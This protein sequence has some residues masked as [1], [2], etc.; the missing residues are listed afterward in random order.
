[1]SLQEK[2]STVKANTQAVYDKGKYDEWDNFW[3]NYQKFSGKG[4]SYIYGFAC[5]G[6]NNE[7][8]KPKKDIVCTNSIRCMFYGALNLEID[9]RPEQFFERFGVNITFSN[10]TNWEQWLAS[11]GIYAVG[12]VD[13]TSYSDRLRYTFQGAKSLKYIEKVILPSTAEPTMQTTNCFMNST[14][15]EHIRFEG[16]IG[17]TLSFQWCTLLT[18]ES[19]KDII[20]HLANYKGTQYEGQKTITFTTECWDRLEAT[21]PPEGFSTWKAYVVSKGWVT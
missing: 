3:S 10:I 9:L 6:W 18:V 7:N 16:I 14:A 13:V 17:N 12:T 15:I 19:L 20:E 4:M 11:S 2:I 1:M 21:T 5:R 8:F